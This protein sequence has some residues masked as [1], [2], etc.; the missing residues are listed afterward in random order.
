ME[1][2]LATQLRG[3]NTVSAM[4]FQIHRS[5]EPDKTHTSIPFKPKGENLNLAV[6]QVQDAFKG[7]VL[8][9]AR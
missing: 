6:L 4:F 3:A 8:I 9:P 5:F 7:N 1:R 2:T